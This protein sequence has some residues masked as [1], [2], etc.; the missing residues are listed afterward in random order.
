M[1]VTVYEP[2]ALFAE[3]QLRFG[4]TLAVDARGT[5][6]ASPPRDARRVRL[7][8]RALFPG[9]VNAHSHA[10]QRGL[11]G[12]TEFVARGQERDDFWTWREAMYQLAEALQPE[13]VYVLS[14]HAFLEMALAG[15]TSVGEFHYLH[16]QADG[17]AYADPNLIARQVITAAKDVG[18]RICLLNVAY[19]RAGF[20]KAPEP[21]QRRFID[22][23]M[24]T[25]FRRTDDLALAVAGDPLVNV[26][27]APHSVRAV[28]FKWLKEFRAV[29]NGRPLHIHVGEQLREIAES[30]AEYGRRPTRVLQ[31][32]ELLQ[33][34]TTL[35]HSI[36]VSHEEMSD[37]TRARSRVC[38]CPTTERNLG[39][40]VVPADLLGAEGV[41]LCLGSDSQ[42]TIDLLEEARLL[43]SHLR[44][45]RQR[46][47]V[48]HDR[49]GTPS[50][51]A[52]E[53]FRAATHS[54]AQSLQHNAG[55]LAPGSQADFFTVDLEHAALA[56]WTE[57][58][59]F[60]MVVLAVPAAAIREVA[61]NGTPIVSDGKHPS[62]ELSTRA[63]SALMRRLS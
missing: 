41:E 14:R 22:A 1:E 40:G 49:S 47:S 42:A 61:V 59:L 4:A 55:T 46:R 63:V 51:V 12:R 6:L 28:P 57:E 5:V 30:E 50:A 53:V 17:T 52:A 9:L 13:D 43:E 56:G 54:G 31:D 11:R 26:G 18:I 2:D 35:V 29:A 7:A 8:G 16:H 45:V 39:D 33:P 23:E 36:Q 15:V 58:T 21:R 24:S 38:A 62:T 32:A 60:P 34:N 25:Y 27:Y 19:A 37:I 3:G 10:F 48:L 20:Q 44:L